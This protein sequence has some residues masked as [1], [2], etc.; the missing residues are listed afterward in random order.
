MKQSQYL[1]LTFLNSW[2]PIVAQGHHGYSPVYPHLDDFTRE[3]K[4]SL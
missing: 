4:F 3:T 1:S 2:E